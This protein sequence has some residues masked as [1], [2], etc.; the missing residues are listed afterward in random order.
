MEEERNNQSSK[1]CGCWEDVTITYDFVASCDYVFFS[2]MPK[3]TETSS[4]L[5][6]GHPSTNISLSLCNVFRSQWNIREMFDVIIIYF[7]RND[8]LFSSW[9]WI[10]M[11]MKVLNFI[12]L[13]QKVG[14]F[15][16]LPEDVLMED[17]GNLLK[18]NN[19]YKHYSSGAL[20]FKVDWKN[21]QIKFL[22]PFKL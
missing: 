7:L 17:E 8:F 15:F 11:I 10:I 9:L 14:V 19:N 1:L 6:Y 4:S 3:V 18:V 12:A 20:L 2:R 21:Q 13:P 16:F 22:F 5:L